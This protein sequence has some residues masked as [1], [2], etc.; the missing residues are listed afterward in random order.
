M[1]LLCEEFEIGLLQLRCVDCVDSADMRQSSLTSLVSYIQENIC[2]LFCL[3]NCDDGL[4]NFFLICL[5]FIWVCFFK[6]SFSLGV[7]ITVFDVW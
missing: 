5:L 1:T 2:W 7:S 4:C 3:R 6:I